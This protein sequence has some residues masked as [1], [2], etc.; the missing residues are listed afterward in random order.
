MMSE[1]ALPF[2]KILFEEKGDVMM[3]RGRM[4]SKLDKSEMVGYGLSVSLESESRKY[5]RKSSLSPTRRD[6]MRTEKRGK[7]FL[8][9]R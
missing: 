2:S 4:K 8:K 5:L 6:R 3:R 7:T 9:K 1:R